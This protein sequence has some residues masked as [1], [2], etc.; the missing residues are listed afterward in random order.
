[1][2]TF[3]EIERGRPPGK[4]VVPP[5][6]WSNTWT[7]RPE[8]D[9]CIGLRFIADVDL[10]DARI[11]AYRR[12][13]ELFP[14]FES[15][16]DVRE[17]FVASFQD[18]LMRFVVGRGA[19]D[20]NDVHKHWTLWNAAPEDMARETLT[21]KGAQ[22]IFDA[23]ERMRIENDIGVTVASDEDLALLPKLLERMPLVREKS[24]TAELRLRRL[25]RYVLEELEG[26]S[27][28]N[29]ETASDR[30]DAKARP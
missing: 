12:A 16:E 1:M 18:S 13:K 29:D 7:D 28:A 4:V 19:C 15:S 8:E 10:E 9:V 3:G 2:S 5:E 22:L 27:L 17:L 26:A 25:L 24:R 6:A 30:S 20:P 21:D 14:E 11:E 23:W